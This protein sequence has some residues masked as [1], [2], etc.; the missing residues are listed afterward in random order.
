MKQT[1][2]E[3]GDISVDVTFKKIK[4]LNLR[5][6]PPFGVVRISAPRRMS[7]NTIR[8][9]VVSRQ[10]WIRKKQHIVRSLPKA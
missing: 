8:D 10:D 5:V 3:I 7:I 6:Y 2:L 4:N 1:S 9:F